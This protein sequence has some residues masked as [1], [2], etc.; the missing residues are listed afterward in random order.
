MLVSDLQGKKV[1]RV[2]PEEKRER[3]DGTERDPKKLGKIHYPVF[4]PNGDR[5][6]G[7]MVSLPDIAG[8]I[9]Q[10][11]C[12]VS[13]D[14]FDSLQGDLVAPDDKQFYDKDAAKR[15]GIDLDACIIF[16]GMDVRTQ[17]GEDLGHCSDARFDEKTGEVES[18][19]LTEGATSSA[20]I[21]EREMPS[22]YLVGYSNGI[23]TVKDEAS[24]LEF[25]GG[26]AAKA[27]EASVKVS[28]SVKKG[29]AV[30]DE[31]GS[32]A[33]DKGSKALG[34]Q[35]GKAKSTIDKNA[36]PAAEKGSEALEKGSRALG[37]QLGKTKNAFGAFMDEY[38][39]AAGDSPKK[40]K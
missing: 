2:L 15:L 22:S 20:L 23:V 26:A 35:L 13:L 32:E 40:E 38:K 28:N 1:Y 7:F 11:D 33:L 24:K 36:A 37:K 39:K 25:N 30:V 31:K 10:D 16:T 18:F 19:L 29:A 3:R 5:M 12:F 34:K 9:K 8:M 17:S 21:G 14:A 27:G 6:V 4:T